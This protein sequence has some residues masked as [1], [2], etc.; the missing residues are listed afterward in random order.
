MK[1]K[2][3]IAL[4]GGMDPSHTPLKGP[5]RVPGRGCV[6]AHRPHLEKIYIHHVASFPIPKKDPLVLC[7]GDVKAFYGTTPVR[8]NMLA[9]ENLQLLNVHF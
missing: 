3:C 6:L 4:E 9:R 1:L 5:V 8:I 2:D 7:E